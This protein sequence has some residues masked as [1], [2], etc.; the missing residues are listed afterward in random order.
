MNGSVTRPGAIPIIKSLQEA[1]MANDF[2]NDT[3]MNIGDPFQFTGT[4]P[5]VSLHPSA[6]NALN[7]AAFKRMEDARRHDVEMTRK[8]LGLRHSAI[9]TTTKEDVLERMRRVHQPHSGAPT[10]AEEVDVVPV[11]S[12][13]RRK[14]KCYGTDITEGVSDE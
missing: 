13:K 12:A 2:R 14:K 8:R 3:L 6:I 4:S 5:H 7:D 10:C 9:K 1:Y 11:K